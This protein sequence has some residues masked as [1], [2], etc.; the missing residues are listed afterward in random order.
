MTTVVA[1]D[2]AREMS[3]A[4]VRVEPA[5]TWEVIVSTTMDPEMDP[6]RANFSPPA[7]PR[8]TLTI[9]SE[10]VDDMSMVEPDVMSDPLTRVVTELKARFR[11]M[12]APTAAWDVEMATP[13]DT[14][15]Q[16]SA[17][18]AVR[19]TAPP[20][21]ITLSV[22][23]DSTVLMNRLKAVEPARANFSAPPPATV[24]VTTTAPSSASLVKEP[25]VIRV[26]LSVLART[27]LAT[28][29]PAMDTPPPKVLPTPMAPARLKIPVKSLALRR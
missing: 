17:S 15:T 25:E 19:L 3:P 14:A 21:W 18:V 4:A 24:T 16:T 1:S 11:P 29:F 9:V 6:P 28:L 7:P 20:A 23:L 2:A 22:T 5:A 26:D 13:P 10:A 27:V 12:A 8:V